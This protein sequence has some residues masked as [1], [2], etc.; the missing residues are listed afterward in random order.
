VLHNVGYKCQ[1]LVR[2]STVL[3]YAIVDEAGI[4]H[5]LRAFPEL[6]KTFRDLEALKKATY[7]FHVSR[8]RRHTSLGTTYIGSLIACLTDVRTTTILRL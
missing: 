3:Y 8:W 1:L 2:T 4:M 7:T 5:L 6:L